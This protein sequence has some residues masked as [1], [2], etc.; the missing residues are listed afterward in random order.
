[1]GRKI[2]IRVVRKEDKVRMVS[3]VKSRRVRRAKVVRGIVEVE[4]GD[5]VIYLGEIFFFF[6]FV[7]SY[8][9]HY[10]PTLDYLEAKV[11]VDRLVGA[12]MLIKVSQY[13]YLP[14][15]RRRDIHSDNLTKCKVRMN[16]SPSP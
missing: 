4:R 7:F 5:V 9:R 3:M 8:L 10:P 14:L 1:M 13:R 2:L 15:N 6:S 16:Q 12:Q 11:Y